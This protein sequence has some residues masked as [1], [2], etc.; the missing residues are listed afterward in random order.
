MIDIILSHQ[1]GEDFRSIT[2][3]QISGHPYSKHM[4][5]K[6]VAMC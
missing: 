6:W 3:S 5:L 1:V 4:S 2:W